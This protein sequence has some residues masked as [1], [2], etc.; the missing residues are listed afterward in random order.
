MMAAVSLTPVAQFIKTKKAKYLKD[1]HNFL[2]VKNSVRGDVTW[3]K[4]IKFRNVQC[5]AR[6][7]TVVVGDQIVFRSVPDHCHLS[8]INNVKSKITLSDAYNKATSNPTV[9]PCVLYQEM[10][11]T[12]REKKEMVKVSQATF[13]RNIQHHRQKS[14]G[15]PV[16]PTTLREAVDLL[17]DAF[18]KTGDGDTYLIF[19]GHVEDDED[20]PTAEK[21]EEE[22]PEDANIDYPTLL[23]FMS[24]WGRDLLR[25][26]KLWF[27]DGTF[28]TCPDLR[29]AG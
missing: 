29:P 14:G 22:N 4:C 16:R 21:G 25:T 26:C 9:L 2:Y 1:A 3:W 12:A 13:A 15:I 28:K 19:A 24:N 20:E 10:V 7:S 23:I 27:A 11:T 5:K 8:N 17:T 6:A 18:K